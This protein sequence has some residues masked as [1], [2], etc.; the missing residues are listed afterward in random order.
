VSHN[1]PYRHFRDKQ[2]LVWAVATQGFDLLTAS[3]QEAMSKGHTAEDRLRLAGR[4]YLQFALRWPQHIQVMFDLPAV[5]EPPASAS[6]AGRRAFQTLLDAV[7]AVQAAGG[8]PAGDP[9]P[10]AVVAWSGV[11]GLAKLAISGRL[12]FD[13]K[14]TVEFTGYLTRALSAGIASLPHPCF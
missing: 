11:H 6:V 12:P 4:G 13:T 9:L 10:L 1:A 2:D 5:K 7:V 14:Q 8:L 3:M